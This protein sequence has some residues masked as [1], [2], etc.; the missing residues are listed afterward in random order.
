M[1]QGQFDVAILG[2]GIGG[3]MLA[4]ILARNGLRVVLVEGGTHPRFA[5]GESLVPE[6]SLRIKLLSARYDVP[7]I[8][9]LGSFH[10]LRNHVSSNCGVKRSFAFAYHR[11]GEEHVGLESSELP[12]LAPPFGP[13]AHL[14]RQDTDHWLL[15]LAAQY[16]AEV[17]QQTMVE[18]V[19]ISEEGVTL[20]IKN[21]DTIEAKFV[22]D[23]TGRRALLSRQFGLLDSEPRFRTNTRG[24]FT[25]MV[26]VVP[27]DAVGPTRKEHG[28]PV[29]FSQSTL[30]HV[31][32]GGWIWVI[33]FDNHR[34]S[35]SPLCSV[36]MILDR[37][38]WGESSDLS[39][40]A[41]FREVVARFPSVRRQFQH[42][43]SI[44]PWTSSRRIQFSSSTT[45][46]HRFCLLPHAAAFVDPL[47]SSGMSLTVGCIDL[48]AQRIL[49]AV[50]EDR[51]EVERFRPVDD[52]VQAGLDHYDNII[53]NSF[54]SWRYY[55]TWNAWNR[56]WAIGNYLGTWGPLQ[57]LVKWHQTKERS[58]LEQL[59]TPEQRGLLA[60]QHSEFISLRDDAEAVL[61]EALSGTLTPAQAAD[62]IFA[63]I[64]ELDFIPGHVR[65]SE[66]QGGRAPT[67]FTLLTG[68]RHVLW[69]RWRAPAAWRAYCAFP[70]RTYAWL[71]ARHCGRSLGEASAR[72]WRGIRDVF[73][74]NNSDWRKQRPL[75]GLPQVDSVPS[76][77]VENPQNITQKQAG[78]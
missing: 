68:A 65:F 55:D 64:G 38:V 30:H 14:L 40:E 46:G 9:H 52:F 13:D 29:P 11:E 50:S 32:E 77:Q 2:S 78:P 75:V 42:A 51:F 6:T 39:P 58:Y 23:G 62:L 41:E 60:S 48:L 25:H 72:A 35:T 61:K 3:S 17:R 15:M 10:A 1:M 45:V 36:G 16:G 12:T 54:D 26:D 31:F 63:R 21:G 4:A 47:Y 44:R 19:N 70:L 59:E 34:A 49:D 73:W 28:M 18:D 8:G 22:V 5:I 66:K 67:V 56:I 71:A 43:K 37:R 24:L 53:A 20:G 27:Y 69:Y 33:P 7:Q 74:S 76:R 57:K